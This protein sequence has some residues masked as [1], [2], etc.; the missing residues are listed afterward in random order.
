[1]N[2]EPEQANIIATFTRHKRTGP[3]KHLLGSYY[4]DTWES[5]DYPGYRVQI[6]YREI[7]EKKTSV[8]FNDE[9]LY[10]ADLLTGPSLGWVEP[11]CKHIINNLKT[12]S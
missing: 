6:D 12:G 5:D 11:L 9:R 8:W 1:M 4:T 3:N 10:E 7:G 2:L